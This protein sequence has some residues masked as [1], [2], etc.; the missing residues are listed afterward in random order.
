MVGLRLNVG[1]LPQVIFVECRIRVQIAFWTPLPNQVSE[2]SECARAEHLIDKMVQSASL[3]EGSRANTRPATL[4]CPSDQ[5]IGT[6]PGANKMDGGHA[7]DAGVSL[8]STIRR[9]PA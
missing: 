1:R 9:H 3:V 2:R 5:S 6:Y 7:D 8:P 4:S